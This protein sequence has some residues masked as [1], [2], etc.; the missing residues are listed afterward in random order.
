MICDRYENGEAAADNVTRP[1]SLEGLTGLSLCQPSQHAQ[2][3]SRS[4]TQPL[5][6]RLGRGREVDDEKAELDAED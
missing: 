4:A 1:T 6:E 5:H 2:R 3:R